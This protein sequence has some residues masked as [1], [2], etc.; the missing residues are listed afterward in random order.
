MIEPDQ[1]IAYYR[2]EPASGWQP[3]DGRVIVETSVSLTVNGEIW[4]T[5]N[6]SPTQLEALAAGFLFNEGLLRTREEI[7]SV[8]PCQQN[9]NIDIWLQHSV[10]KPLHWTRTSGCTGG[11]TAQQAPDPGLQVPPPPPPNDITYT[12]ELILDNMRELLHTQDLYRAA[13][14][15]HTSALSDGQRFIACAEDIGRHNTIDKLSGLVLLDKLDARGTLLLTTGRIS[16]EM[17]QKAAALQVRVVASRTSPTSESI[18]RAQQ[19]GITLVGYARQ[20]QL[21]VYTH[22]EGL[23]YHA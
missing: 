5:F 19:A 21:L 12:P 20:N 6:C 11:I 22:P 4:L 9:T 10:Q 7:A 8:Y 13:G 3:V 1:P 16:S 23:D 15:V 14:G 18:A 2:Y 17:L